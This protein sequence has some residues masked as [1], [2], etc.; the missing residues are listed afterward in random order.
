MKLMKQNLKRKRIED[1]LKKGSLVKLSK[2][3]TFSFYIKK[4]MSLS[5]LDFLGIVISVC[6]RKAVVYSSKSDIHE[7]PIHLLEEI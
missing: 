6:N 1:P 5:D 4:N 2:K 3:G 7:Y